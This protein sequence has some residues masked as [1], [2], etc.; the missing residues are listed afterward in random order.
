MYCE[1]KGVNIIVPPKIDTFLSITV[2][3][4]YILAL[5][6]ELFSILFKSCCCIIF[7]YQSFSCL[8]QFLNQDTVSVYSE[9]RQ[10]KHHTPKIC[11]GL[12]GRLLLSLVV[13]LLMLGIYHHLRNIIKVTIFLQNE[14]N[15]SINEQGLWERQ[16]E[17]WKSVRR[18]I[19]WDN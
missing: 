2:Q 15:I 16:M 17:K 12:E 6:M 8:D 3:Y 18:G 9:E 11:F 1:W 10:E 14:S 7:L 5:V 13:W 4:S 19:V